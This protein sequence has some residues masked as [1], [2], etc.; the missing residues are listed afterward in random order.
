[1]YKLWFLFIEFTKKCFYQ[2]YLLFQRHM[3]TG[4]WIY[5]TISLRHPTRYHVEFCK[6]MISKI[7][8]DNNNPSLHNIYIW[9]GPEEPSKADMFPIPRW[10]PQYIFGGHGRH[11]TLRY[12]VPFSRCIPQVNHKFHVVH[13]LRGKCNLCVSLLFFF[14]SQFQFIM[15]LS[16]RWRDFR[17]W[18]RFYSATQIKFVL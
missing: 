17:R 8:G 6:R 3:T 12:G 11:I 10:M 7:N 18:P 16:R 13:I 4:S 5:T 14:C 1:M 2:K 9:S 15:I